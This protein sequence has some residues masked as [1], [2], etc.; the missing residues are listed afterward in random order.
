MTVEVSHLLDTSLL[1]HA[2]RN[3]PT[4]QGAKALFAPGAGLESC[5]ISVVSV[6]EILALARI[7]AW[8]EKRA[9]TLQD[10]LIRIAPLDINHPRI[11]AAYAEI[12]HFGHT[13]GRRMGKN[14]LWIAATARATGLTL[15]TTDRDF[16]HLQASHLSRILLDPESGL[17]TA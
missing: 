5:T 17:P 2:V 11:L 4:W 10:V 12:D 1:L 6:G 13:I 3:S 7:F 14:D 8:G 9:N 16:D 15:L